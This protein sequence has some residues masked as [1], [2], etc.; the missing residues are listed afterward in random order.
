MKIVGES[1]LGIEQDE[2]ILACRQLSWEMS[3][4]WGSTDYMPEQTWK[5]HNP[6]YKIPYDVS[7]IA[8]RL[9]RDLPILSRHPAPVHPTHT[10][11]AECLKPGTLVRAEHQSPIPIKVPCAPREG[12]L[13]R[14]FPH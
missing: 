1:V 9:V 6:E 12:R 3:E 8:A 2:S 7:V 5:D 14:G 13:A 11:I 4:V 10:L